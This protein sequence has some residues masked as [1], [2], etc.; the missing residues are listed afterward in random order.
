MNMEELEKDRRTR[1]I[2]F[3]RTYYNRSIVDSAIEY[4]DCEI[5]RRQSCFRD[6]IILDLAKKK[7]IS[8]F[9]F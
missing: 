3:L 6:P 9:F 2:E 5:E 7:A 4:A 1:Q 8:K